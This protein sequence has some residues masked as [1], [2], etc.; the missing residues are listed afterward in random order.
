VAAGQQLQPIITW[1]D[2]GVGVQGLDLVEQATRRQH[3]TATGTW[4]STGSGRMQLA[5]RGVSIDAIAAD[6][7]RQPDGGV[8]DA[9]AEITGTGSVPAASSDFRI[10]QAGFAARATIGW[11]AMWI[12]RGRV[13]GGR[14]PSTRRR[15]Y[16]SPAVGTVP[17][18]W[19]STG[20][21]PAAA[22]CT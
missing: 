10:S 15:T 22:D 6:E 21:L 17:D 12:Q 1:T 9:T 5:A 3:L 18:E 13:P 19:C 8:L 7:G 14:A 2:T 11:R 4:D 16:F 20:G